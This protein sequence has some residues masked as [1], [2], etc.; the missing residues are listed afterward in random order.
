ME[1][2]AVAAGRQTG[3]TPCAD[4]NGGCTHLCLFRQKSH[5]CACPDTPDE[6]PCS[7]GKTNVS[8]NFCSSLK[9]IFLK[10]IEGNQQLKS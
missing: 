5:V 7:T 1:I 6:K 2:R 3:W 9:V 10:R 8:V 4:H